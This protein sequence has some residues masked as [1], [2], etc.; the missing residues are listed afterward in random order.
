MAPPYPRVPLV[1]PSHA[2]STGLVTRSLPILGAVALV[3]ALGSVV[4]PWGGEV[5]PVVLASGVEPLVHETRLEGVSAT[6][7]VEVGAGGS[8]GGTRTG[9]D[10]RRKPVELPEVERFDPDSRLLDSASLAGLS[11]SV[12]ALLK[13]EAGTP[14]EAS[15]SDSRDA[16]AH[17]AE[18]ASWTDLLEDLC[19][20][21]VRWNA[22]YAAREL[23]SRVYAGAVGEQDWKAA[24][25]VLDSGDRQQEVLTTAL[26]MRMVD[27]AA[28]RG[29][30]PRPLH[31]VLRERA[32]AWL[33]GA[34]STAYV[35]GL[36]ATRGLVTRT[37]MVHVVDLQQDLGALAANP[38]HRARF[39]AAFVLGAT[40]RTA[41]SA[42]VA[43]A[44]LP[45][46][47][48]NFIEGDA[49]MALHA[50]Q[51][52]G[53]FVAPEL[54]FARASADAQQ[55]RCIEALLAECDELGSSQR[56]DL[57]GISW[58][59]REPLQYWGYVHDWD[60]TRV[61]PWIRKD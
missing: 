36:M 18:E 59:T 41:W 58:R 55:A 27:Q 35:P 2:C 37:C 7:P 19:D 5:R 17:E 15:P 26:L 54:A 51:Q 21:G 22:T 38:T 4:I 20:D 31:P 42:V 44:L 13:K 30:A 14:V 61:A 34:P 32:L 48:A 47:R 57:K 56:L 8:T 50:L 6:L 29:G 11:D 24:E 45:H 10:R 1:S 49:C 40:G 53:P 23:L 46:L 43:E 60:R 39:R 28:Q 12:E 33:D 16:R 52:L 25:A 9:G 3:L